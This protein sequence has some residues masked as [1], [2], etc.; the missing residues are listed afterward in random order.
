MTPLIRPLRSEDKV[1]WRELYDG[2]LHF[3]ETILS[4]ELIELAWERLIDPEY[5]SY[6]LI[7]EVDGELLGIT[8]YS[9]QTSTW[10]AKNYCYLEDLFVS[11]KA[12]GKGLGRSLIDAVIAI[13]R[14]EG[15]NRV[16]WN[17]DSTNATA[18]KLYDTYTEE[19]GKVQYRIELN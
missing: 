17:T 12:R 2:Y 11:P 16:Y 6:G 15:S 19:S 13:A 14:G 4:D 8:H 10:A 9:F 1:V 18:R 3:Y 7:A 5:D